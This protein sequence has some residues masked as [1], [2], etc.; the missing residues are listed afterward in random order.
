MSQCRWI[1]PFMLALALSTGAAAQ[2]YPTHAIR[3]IV[4]YPAGTGIDVAARIVADALASELGQ[5]I[6]VDNRPGASGNLAAEI[7]AKGDHDGY[8]LL[9]TN[10]AHTINASLYS[11]LNYDPDRDFIPVSLAGTSAEMLVANSDLPVSTVADAIALAR[12]KPGQLNLA[13]AGNGSPSHLSGALFK[14]MAGI[15]LV[16]V[17][18]KG[19]PPALADLVAGRVHFY[20]SGLPPVLPLIAAG[21]VKPIAVTTTS[22]SPAAPNV[23][24]L[25]ESGLPGYEVVLWYGLLA[26][27]GVPDA[28]VARLNRAVVKVLATPQVK[29]RFV[30]QGVDPTSSSIAE[31]RELT[32]TEATRWKTLIESTGIKPD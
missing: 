21:R 31:F 25:A 18:Y 19:A 12:A 17:P 6:V 30:A 9:F 29:E 16:H 11:H 15:D 5:P 20:V 3:L 8:T 7:V 22:R 26:P 23:P 2:S 24:T 10:N 14:Q 28:V 13:S 32:R 27:T 4:A 1:V